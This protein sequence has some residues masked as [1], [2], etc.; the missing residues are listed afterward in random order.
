MG[1]GGFYPLI[2]FAEACSSCLDGEEEDQDQADRECG[3]PAEVGVIIFSSKG[4]LFQFANPSMQNILERY[5]KTCGHSKFPDINNMPDHI[6]DRVTR[7]TEELKHLHSTLIGDNLE[8]LS[9]RDL[10]RLEQQIHDSLGHIRAKKEELLLEQLGEIKEKIAAMRREV[11]A[12]SNVLEKVVE[13]ASCELTGTGHDSHPYTI[14]PQIDA[15][16]PAQRVSDALWAEMSNLQAADEAVAKRWRM[17]EDLNK[18][19][20]CCDEYN[21]SG[22]QQ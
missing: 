17:T 14:A 11:N 18:S 8:R 2:P 4:K 6:T 13:L 9:S 3:D 5:R 15:S 20:A 10:V 12:S 1:N 16:L 22:E 7:F 19:P 21:W